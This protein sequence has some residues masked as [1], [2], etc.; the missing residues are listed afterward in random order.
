MINKKAADLVAHYLKGGD[1]SETPPEEP[2][3]L[4]DPHQEEVD[5][6]GPENAT[7]PGEDTGEQA[8]MKIDQVH[9]PTTSNTTLTSTVKSEDV[10]MEDPHVD[11]DD[12]SQSST[13]SKRRRKQ[14]RRR[15]SRNK[16]QE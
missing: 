12:R 4:S 7:P 8:K 10:K 5:F 16:W 1:G 6:E 15:T 14:S 3:K 2:T 13:S 9:E 11:N